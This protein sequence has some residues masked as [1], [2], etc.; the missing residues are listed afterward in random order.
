MFPGRGWGF[1]VG[2]TTRCR[3]WGLVSFWFGGVGRVGEEFVVVDD[4]LLRTLLGLLGSFFIIMKRVRTPTFNW[5]LGREFDSLIAGQ[6]WGGVNGSVPVPTTLVA[7]DGIDI[8]VDVGEITISA[9]GVGQKGSPGAPGADG[10]DGEK[11]EKGEKGDVGFDGVLGV[12][13]GGTGS[14]SLLVNNRVMVSYGDSIVEGEAQDDG[15]ILIGRTG[16][17]PASGRVVAGS[18]ITVRYVDGN[19]EISLA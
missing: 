10:R 8:A 2:G 15:Q 4:I 5:W 16:M 18:G 14:N 7:G 9:S 12:E 11:G 3:W 6:V 1:V 19:I 13:R 17:S